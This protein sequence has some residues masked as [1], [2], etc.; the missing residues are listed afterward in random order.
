MYLFVYFIIFIKEA[1][2]VVMKGDYFCIIFLNL[3]LL[4]FK[5]FFLGYNKSFCMLDSFK[6]IAAQ[7]IMLNLKKDNKSVI[8]IIML[9]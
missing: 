6:L 9:E 5:E 3:M 7:I 4:I 8:L 2:T 1:K